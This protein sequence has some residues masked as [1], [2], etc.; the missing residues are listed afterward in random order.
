MC[1]SL[2]PRPELVEKEQQLLRCCGER[3]RQA[4]EDPERDGERKQKR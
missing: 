3:L 4:M 1:E 2:L